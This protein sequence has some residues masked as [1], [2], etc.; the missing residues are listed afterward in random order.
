MGTILLEGME[1]FARHGCFSEEQAIGSRFLVDVQLE[2]NVARAAATDSVDDTVNYQ[3][4]Y[5][6]VEREMLVPSKLL[7]HVAG[8]VASSLLHDFGA[9]AAVT[10]KVAK[11][12]P[13]LG[14]GAVRQ[15]SGSLTA[16]REP[17][18]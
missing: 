5:K 10:V 1:F 2:V 16:K 8:R 18:N 14:G 7:E 11:L 12:N 9:I 15:A 13:P 6:V 3:A 17:V 4:A